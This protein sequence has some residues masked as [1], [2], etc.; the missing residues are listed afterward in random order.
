MSMRSAS[1]GWCFGLRR[2]NRTAADSTPKAS[3]MRFSSFW[4]N[5]DKYY[6]RNKWLDITDVLWNKKFE[7]QKF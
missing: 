2:P 1:T 3:E 6:D 5:V 7:F 4:T